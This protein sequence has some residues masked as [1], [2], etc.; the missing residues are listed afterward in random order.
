MGTQKKKDVGFVI[1]SEE[2]GVNQFTKIRPILE[3]KFAD[4]L[5]RTKI[6]T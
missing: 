5:E 4:N 2:T 3:A 1:I 6:I